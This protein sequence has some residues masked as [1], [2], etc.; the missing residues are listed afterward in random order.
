M[1][2]H[3]LLETGRDALFLENISVERLPLVTIALALIAFVASRVDGGRGHRTVLCL[4]QGVAALGTIGLWALVTTG[5][6]W[7]Y[8]VLYVWAGV[9][10]TLI[11]VRFWLLLGDLFTIIEGKR[12]FAF[13]AMGGSVG[14]LVGSGLATVLAP[15][16]GGQGLLLAASASYALST[17]GPLFVPAPS[18]GASP[19]AAAT[20]ERESVGRSLRVLIGDPYAC[21]IAMIVVVAGMTLTLGDYLFKSVLAEEVAPGDLAVWLSRVYLGLNLLSIAILAFG[22][23]PLVQRLGVDRSLALLP[24][25]LAATA[26]GV[27]AGGALVATILLKLVDGTLRYSLHKTATE[28]LYLPMSATLRGAVKSAIDVV[29]GT[30]AKA[31]GSLI[32][33]ALVM[34]PEPRVAIAAA[35]GAMATVWIVLALRLRGAYLDVFRDTLSASAIETAI[36]HPELD[37]EGAG[38]LIRALSDPDEERALAAMRLLAERGQHDLVPSLLLYHPS[39]RVV[40]QALDLFAAVQRDDLTHLLEHLTAHEDANVRA[41]AVRARWVLEHD[42]EGLRVLESSPCLA[43]RVS[44]LAGRIAAGDVEPNEYRQLLDAALVYDESDA[45]LAAAAAARLMYHPIN[46]EPLV[47]MARDEDEEVAREAI[48]AMRASGDDWFTPMLV[49]LLGERRIRNDVRRALIERGQPALAELASRLG[50]SDTPIAIQSHVPRTVAR[51]AEPE[52]AQLLLEGLAKA[53]SGLV[54]FKV[55]RGLEMK[56]RPRGGVGDD[57]RP[58]ASGLDLGPLRREF[59]R[60]F[61]RSVELMRLEARLQRFQREDQGFATVGGELLV[62]LLRDKR[63]LATQRLFIMLGLLHPDEDFGAIRSGLGSARSAERAS[64]QELLETLLAREVA[65]SLIELVGGGPVA[66]SGGESERDA[67]GAWRIDAYAELVAEIFD[68][69]SEILRAVSLYH[70]GELDIEAVANAHAAR[71]AVAPRPA[72]RGGTRPARGT[73]GGLRAVLEFLDQRVPGRRV[74]AR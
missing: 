3:M 40:S 65:Q 46:R 24:T 51:F 21:R 67:R 69:D 64:A 54:R 62:D 66:A 9:I 29:A 7:V 49:D 34:M 10:T 58:P 26:V 57:G 68:D 47:Q 35:F 48:R 55:L 52:A 27:L 4:L 15:S 20:S 22:V 71:R 56:L 31:L 17:I 38:A 43:V 74:A 53:E 41:A 37:L 25:L 36:D 45:R 23:T 28:L 44:A 30:G 6:I 39:P 5:L 73:E 1:A 19:I 60:T 59:D 2:G 50:C 13:I 16:L 61:D 70:V 11:V 32:V 72:G 12:S 18:R 8:Y 63:S 14:A 33:L 42:L